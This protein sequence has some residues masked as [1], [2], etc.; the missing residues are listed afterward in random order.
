MDLIFAENGTVEIGIGGRPFLRGFDVRL[1]LA[2]QELTALELGG[3]TWEESTGADEH[4]QFRVWRRRMFWNGTGVL[5]WVLFLYPW[6]AKV[7]VRVLRDISGLRGSAEFV[8]APV[9]LP[10]FSLEPRLSWLAYTFG[11]DGAE[12]ADPSGGYWPEACLGRLRDG[13]PR[14]PFV[15]LVIH[16]DEGAL[17]IAPGEL[18][19]LSPL[20]TCSGGV[21]RAL[22]GDFPRLSAGTTLSTWFVAGKDPGKALYRLGQILLRLGKK[23]RPDPAEHLFLS[24]LGYWNAYGSYYTELINPMQEKILQSLAAEFR[25]K[26]LPVGYFG[27]DLWYPYSRI[28]QAL[29]FRP[30][31]KKYPRGLGV[32]ARE[33]GIPFLLHLSALSPDNVYGA[34]GEDPGVYETIA[35]ELWG[36]GGIG[37]WH[38]W[39]RTWQYL[40]PLLVQDPWKAEAWFSGMVR[41]FR[42]AGL[43]VLLCMQ[44]MGMVL[45]STQEPNV[46]AARSYTDHLFSLPLA[47]RRAAILDPHIVR[48]K[49]DPVVIWLQNLLVGFVQWTMGVAPFHDLFLSRH[50]PEFGGERAWEEAVMRAL[51]CGPVGF[52]DACGMADARL[53]SRLVLPEGRLAQPDRPPEPLWSTLTSS[54]PVFWTETQAGDLTW[55]YMLALNLDEELKRVRLEPPTGGEFLAWDPQSGSLAD[56]DPVVPPRSLVYRVFIPKVAEAGFL[57]I[58]HLL[59]P[60]PAKAG[61]EIWPKQGKFKVLA[62]R[63]LSLHVVLESGK[64]VP[65]ESWGKAEVQRR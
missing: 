12:K 35:H 42:A 37:V 21:G 1:K 25:A 26:R 3:T 24:R 55:V 29:A 49:R 33:T 27:L 44:T 45:A 2:G 51:S 46:V 34:K 30:E 5:E 48:E 63:D 16:D 57:G 61:I 6:A 17:A 9:L 8:E 22:A 13:L 11:L 15:P 28:G 14:K 50:H 59:V 64:M 19:L 4:G 36:E 62:S 43:P 65:L 20:V 38:D 31:P 52:G 7:E 23:D 32:I 18:F 54:C 58:P 56:A 40:T 10:V 41:A 47:L 53:L 39:L 60:M